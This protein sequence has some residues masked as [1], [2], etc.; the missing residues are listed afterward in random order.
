MTTESFDPAAWENAL[1]EDMR[2]HGGSPSQGPLA[3]DP[4]MLLYSTGAKT[5]E[6]RRAVLTYSRDGDAYVV[7]GTASGAPVDPQWVGN[8]EKTPRVELEVA[9][10]TFQATG[11]VLRDGP[12]RD[13]LWDQH[14]AAV[15]RFGEYP[16][17]TGGRI[18]P[19]IRLRRA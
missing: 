1:I 19:V 5:G 15:P 6:R 13:R 14:V 16:S 18:I 7:A 2:A 4:L 3:G 12:E 11:E 9:N 17:Q 8:I 10:E